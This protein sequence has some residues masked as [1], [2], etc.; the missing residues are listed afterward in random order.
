MNGV[1]L[2]GKSP[3]APIDVTIR[4]EIRA[5]QIIGTACQRFALE[6]FFTLVGFAVTI[7]GAGM[8]VGVAPF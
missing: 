7:E 1:L 3:F 8:T 4:T 5:V 2:L 6:P